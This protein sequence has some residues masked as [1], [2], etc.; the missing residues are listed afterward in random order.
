MKGIK[1]S[2]DIGSHVRYISSQSLE[3]GTVIE[4]NKSTFTIKTSTGDLRVN[5]EKVVS[6][7]DICTVVCD[8]SKD[9]NGNS[10]YFD[11]DNYPNLNKM[12]TYFK[13]PSLY[14]VI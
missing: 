13:E 11:Y 14:H 5:K 12:V 8:S 2:I 9:K 1:H 10:C 7:R 6:V 3:K 4:V